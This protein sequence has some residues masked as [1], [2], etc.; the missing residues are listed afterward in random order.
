MTEYEASRTLVKSPPELW[1]ELS[2]PASLAGHLAEPFGE[3]RI[4]RLE[5]ETAVAWEGER[6]S[7]T[8][9]IEPSGWGTRVTLTARAVQ[10]DPPE[11]RTRLER[12]APEPAPLPLPSQP[13]Q[14]LPPAAVAPPAAEVEP[15]AEVA[16]VPEAPR[17]G[18]RALLRGWLGSKPTSSED[19]RPAS[20]SLPDD[21][22]AAES[23]PPAAESAPAPPDA[24]PPAAESAR[25]TADPPPEAPPAAESEPAPDASPAEAGE[26]VASAIDPDAVLVGVLDKLGAAHHR[27][28]SRG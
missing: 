23:A 19:A 1:A 18:L 13:P 24:A 8:V 9:R 7:G 17:R 6:A 27:P 21:V 2:D 16:V 14:P 3:I 11:M 12:P 4:T 15:A 10:G 5:P 22:P 28:F 20:E 25:P 26:A